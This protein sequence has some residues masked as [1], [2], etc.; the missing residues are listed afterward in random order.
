MA[1]IFVIGGWIAA[2]FAIVVSVFF[3]PVVAAYAF[4]GGAFAVIA[5]LMV[6]RLVRGIDA[7]RLD[8]RFAFLRPR[9]P[10]K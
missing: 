7:W 3:G 8:H 9:R 1:P 2:A 6:A 4:V 10:V 5:V